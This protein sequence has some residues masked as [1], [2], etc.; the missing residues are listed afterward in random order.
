MVALFFFLLPFCQASLVPGHHQSQPSLVPVHH[1]TSTNQTVNISATAGAPS[2]SVFCWPGKHSKLEALWASASF[3]LLIGS[4]NYRVYFGPNVSSVETLAMSRETYWHLT[5][6]PW[7]SKQFRVNP[8]QESCVGIST[9]EPYQVQLEYLAVNLVLVVFTLGSLSMFFLAPFLSR[10]TVV[11]YTAWVTLGISFSLVFLTFLLQKRFR[12]SFFSWVFLAYTLS[13]YLMTTS[14]YNLTT[15]LSSST[16][17]WLLGYCV[18][19]GLF[20]WASLYRMGPPSHP[21]TLSL[22]QWTLQGVS[23]VL[24][25]LSSY[26]TL[27]SSSMAATL[28]LV[29]VVPSGMIFSVLSSIMRLKFMRPKPKRQLLSVGQAQEQSDRETRLALEQ[30]RRYCQSPE[31]NT[32]GL[33]S[34][35]RSPARFAQFVEGGSHVTEEEAIEHR[36]WVSDDETTDHDSTGE[37][38]DMNDTNDTEESPIEPGHRF[39]CFL[40]NDKLLGHRFSCA[41]CI[42]E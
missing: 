15:L 40:C 9:S 29:S 20:S 32:W 31:R 33:V 27:A 7:R 2:L 22:I 10:N 30:L 34:R 6:L 19:T 16:Y 35:L 42:L 5:V 13:L 3:Q 38:T 37:D 8:F 25:I 39:S 12:Q 24:L 1:L 18:V 14:W 41:L 11:H 23:L 26:N 36:N 17:P 4:D 28:L 21:R